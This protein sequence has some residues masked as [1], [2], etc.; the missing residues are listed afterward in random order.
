MMDSSLLAAESEL[1]PVASTSSS[2][3]T[4]ACT[5]IISAAA[6]HS[7]LQS[8]TS[9]NQL[10]LNGSAVSDGHN[11]LFLSQAIVPLAPSSHPAPIRL[12]PFNPH[13]HSIISEHGDT[14]DTTIDSSASS[15]RRNMVVTAQTITTHR[16]LQDEFIL[17][18]AGGSD[19]T[20]SWCWEY[21]SKYDLNHGRGDY[22]VC[23]LCK[24]SKSTN[25]ASEVSIGAKKATSHLHQHLQH[26]HRSVW[27]E[28][29]AAEQKQ[30]VATAAKQ[31]TLTNHLVHGVNAVDSFLL[32]TCMG[33]GSLSECE[34]PY[35]RQMIAGKPFHCNHTF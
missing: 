7:G 2:S 35:F 22:V 19:R 9:I 5:G 20:T 15:V 16:N 1:L 26:M 18:T 31:S 4:A 17:R 21:F 3:L 14:P 32:W 13:I 6:T 29:I 12:E 28:H 10:S 25:S 33:M 27:D 30:L 34:N 8:T 24:K 23:L 11:P